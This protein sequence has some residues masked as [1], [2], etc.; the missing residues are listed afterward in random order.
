MTVQMEDVLA[1][2]LP[3][4]WTQASFIEY[5]SDH[6]CLEMLQFALAAAQYKER[7][8]NALSA[9]S[10][11]L[12][13]PSRDLQDLMHSWVSL[14]DTYLLPG[15]EC[16]V[17]LPSQIRDPIL[18]VRLQKRAADPQ[19]LE[20]AIQ[21]TWEM[22]EGLVLSSFRREVPPQTCLVEGS[23]MPCH[24]DIPSMHTGSEKGCGARLLRTL[25][26]AGRRTRTV[27]GALFDLFARHHVSRSREH[28]R[29][30]SC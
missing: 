1:E 3:M 17:N 20:P 27:F 13:L 15:S 11:K 22:M 18:R 5:F 2:R 24:Y 6:Y 9:S 16:E 7:Y 29:R 25:Q 19:V 23:Y 14:V 26:S 30:S 8:E 21:A 10:R 4:F 12:S 28:A